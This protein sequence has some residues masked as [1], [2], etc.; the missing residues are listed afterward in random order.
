M[1]YTQLKTVKCV[2][3]VCLDLDHYSLSQ[4]YDRMTVLLLT[5]QVLQ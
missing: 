5:A 1:H 4:F 2:P 3:G